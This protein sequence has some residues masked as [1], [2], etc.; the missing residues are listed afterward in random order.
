MVIED[1]ISD[2]ST[3]YDISKEYASFLLYRGGLNIY[4]AMD[5]SIQTVLENYYADLNNFPFDDDQ[6]YPQSA[7]IILDPYTGDILGV[8]GAIGVKNADRI[9]NYATHAKRP[10]G[11]AIK[12]I[13]VYAQAF[14]QEIIKWSS[15]VEDSPVTKLDGK[16][17][18]PSNANGKYM[19]NVTVKYAIEHSLNTVAVKLLER[20]GAD[21]SFDFLKNNLHINSLDKKQDI[22]SASLALGQPSH[23]ITLRELVGAYTIFEEG[24]M[25]RPR[26]YYKVTDQ[27]GKIILDNLADQKRQI[28]RETAAIM[29]KLLESVVDSGTAKGLITLDEKISVAGKTGTTQ[30]NYDRFFVGYTP[31]LLA[32]TWFGYEYPK[33]LD[34]FGGNYAAIFWDEVMSRIYSESDHKYYQQEFKMPDGVQ[35]LTYDA[36]TGEIPLYTDRDTLLEDGW[37]KRDNVHISE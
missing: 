5:Q 17:D 36:E 20:V 11:S 34:C 29:T 21:S 3:K 13:S 2:L 16:R 35:K 24:I 6:N 25:S 32:G 33:N 18:W 30:G 28:S 15:I 7:M 27:N 8:A 12:P 4:T 31:E 9:Q 23:G 37:F 10:P 1:V 14:E 22:G 19:G 26:S